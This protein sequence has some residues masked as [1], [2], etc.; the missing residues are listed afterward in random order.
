MGYYVLYLIYFFY[1]KYFQ[2]HFEIFF[3]NLKNKNQKTKNQTVR[4]I[5]RLLQPLLLR[6]HAWVFPAVQSFV[7]SDQRKTARAGS[8]SLLLG[9]TPAHSS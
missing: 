3:K 1:K 4:E 9:Q 5:D 2:I 7:V 8:A 6:L